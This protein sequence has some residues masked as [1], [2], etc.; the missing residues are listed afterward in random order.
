[1]TVFCSPYAHDCF[2]LVSSG[3]NDLPC[4]PDGSHC[5]AALPSRCR[6]TRASSAKTTT[7]LRQRLINCSTQPS[8]VQH[9]CERQQRVVSPTEIVG[10][11][12]H[13]HVCSTGLT[14]AARGWCTSWRWLHCSCKSPWTI[15]IWSPF[16]H[17][18]NASDSIELCKKG[19]CCTCYR[20][21]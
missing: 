20:L 1:M 12:L 6:Q 2:L 8:L 9:I 10:V 18:I 11:G 16:L 19:C 17:C 5:C 14:R 3:A 15:S 21:L 4:T 13:Q 7:P